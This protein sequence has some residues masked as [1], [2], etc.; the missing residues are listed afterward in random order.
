MYPVSQ[1]WNDIVATGQHWYET[2]VIVNGVTYPQSQIFEL[3]TNLRMFAEEYPVVGGCLAAELTLKMLKPSVT[4]PRMALI[5]PQVRVCNGYTAAYQSE[6]IPQGFFFFDTREDSKNDDG[7]DVITFHAYDSMLK[8][9]MMYPSTVTTWPKTDINTVKDIAYNMQLQ[10]SRTGTSGIDQRTIDLMNRGYQI[11]APVSY[12]LRETLGN[13]G[14]M[15]AGNWII[16]MENKL[17]LVAINGIPKETNLLIDGAGNI[18]TFGGDAI[19]LVDTS[20]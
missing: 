1:K 5:R 4:I 6:W 13:I 16:T 17:L 9:E 11:S 7:L 19:S 18:I 3:R 12:T 20:V 2:Q 15:Y 14:A 8:A 10:G